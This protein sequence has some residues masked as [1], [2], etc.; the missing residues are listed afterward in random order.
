MKD[1]IIKGTG[2]SR[3]LKGAGWPAS[4]EEFKS[5]AEAGTLPFDF[6]G[7]NAAGWQQIGDALNKANLLGDATC[8]VLGIPRTAVVNDALLGLA[9]G[10]GKYGFAI[11]LL[12]PGGRPLANQEIVGIT[13][14]NGTA[15]ITDSNGYVLA[16]A[17]SANPTVSIYLGFADIVN[18]QSRTLTA[19]G[20][21]TAVTWTLTRNSTVS[22]AVSTS[23]TLYFSPD[24]STITA[25]PIGGGGSGAPGYKGSDDGSDVYAAGGGGGQGY[26]VTQQYTNTNHVA[27]P[28][29]ITIGAGG[30]AVSA[31]TFSPGND[32][33]TTQ[34]SIANGALTVTASGGGGGKRGN[35]Y[36]FVGGAGG[37]GNPSG[38]AGTGAYHT[39]YGGAGG[40]NATYSPYGNGG[41]GGGGSRTAGYATDSVAGYQGR[42]Y[43]AWAF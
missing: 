24:V 5:M 7:I 28:V 19:T 25:T 1:G 35:A 36:P 13:K 40:A 29:S 34:V 17:T 22:C 11:T 32:G 9:I 6:N 12:T 2:N 21:I 4:Y 26:A 30:V 20:V 18:S 27:V 3:Y 8:D 38:G 42:A 15:A 33:G 37:A 23:S 16:V 10:A 31:S 43:L 39:A 14:P 41:A